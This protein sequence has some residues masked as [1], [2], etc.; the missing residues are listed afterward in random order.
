MVGQSSIEYREEH[1]TGNRCKICPERI[2][3]GIGATYV[4]PLHEE[5]CPFCPGSVGEVTP[6]FADGTRIRIG[7]SVTFPNLF[8]FAAHH[9]V[10]VMTRSHL[11]PSFSPEVIVDALSGQIE[12][13]MKADFKG[14]PSINWNF[15]PSSGASIVHP[16]LQGLLDRRPCPRAERYLIAGER[17]LLREGRRYWD[18]LVSVERDSP[19]FLFGDEMFWT[20]AAVPLGEREVWGVMPFSDL[21][22]AV[23]YLDLLAHGIG[24]VIELFRACGSHAFNLSLFLDRSREHHGFRSFCSM[25]ARINPNSTSTSDSA[26][27]ERIHGEPVI[28]TLPEE[29]GIFGRKE[30][31]LSPPV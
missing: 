8:P 10:T 25:I 27:M 7:E 28:L 4:P 16:H 26:F 21:E 22:G 20:A 6:L 30:Y 1:L 31:D 24:E 12:G 2:R 11:P 15:L 18:D 13:L 23:P 19:R 5:G 14:Y 9:V 29:L 3:R 17:Y